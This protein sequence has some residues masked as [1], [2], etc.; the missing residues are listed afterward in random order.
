MKILSSLVAWGLRGFGGA[1]DADAAA[2][3]AA[4]VVVAVVELSVTGFDVV[5]RSQ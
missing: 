4:D 2:I 3:A 5:V 1:D